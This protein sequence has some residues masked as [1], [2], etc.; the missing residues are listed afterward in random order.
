MKDILFRGYYKP[1]SKIIRGYYMECHGVPCIM[2][3]DNQNLICAVEPESVRQ[4]TGAIDVNG[5]LVYEGDS[6]EVLKTKEWFVVR[7][8][9]YG[10]G[11]IGFYA[12]FCDPDTAYRQDLGWWLNGRAV[13]VDERRAENDKP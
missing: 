11:H 7:Y 1:E 9:Q 13:V 10:D 8:G 3:I 6:M 2:D 12:D 5:T 4:W